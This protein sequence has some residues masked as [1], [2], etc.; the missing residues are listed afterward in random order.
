MEKCCV[1]M[2]S[3]YFTGMVRENNPEDLFQY[4]NHPFPFSLSD[5]G[6]LSPPVDKDDLVECLEKS[7]ACMFQ[8][9]Q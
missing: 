3:M 2:S 5:N 6:T 1:T 4:E 7:G 8:M 9:R